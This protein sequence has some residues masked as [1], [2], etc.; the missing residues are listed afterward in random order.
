MIRRVPDLCINFLVQAE[1]LRLKAY[2]DSKG[3]WTIGVGHT[4]GVRQGQVISREQAMAFAKDDASHAAVLLAGVLTESA[5]LSLSEH[6]WSALI[7]FTFNLGVK[8]S[9]TIW[10]KIN[11]GDLD[12]VPAQM[13][14][15]VYVTMDDGT[16]VKLPGLVNRRDAEVKLWNTGDAPAA[17]LIAHPLKGAPSTPPSSEIRNIETPPTV[18]EKPLAKA[19]LTTKVV[20]VV[21]ATG[22]A[23]QEVL[24]LVQPHADLSPIFA[25]IAIALTLVVVIAGAIGLFIAH[26]QHKVAK[27]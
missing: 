21:A 27:L 9:W 2:Q 25:N 16:A 11:A 17:A 4:Q 1:A 15:F 14:R 7:S 26:R 3:V 20:G 5:I 23:A 13:R 24:P 19:S 12:A 6:Q 10:K 18:E 8:R 22:V